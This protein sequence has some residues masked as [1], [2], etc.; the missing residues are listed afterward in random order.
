[1]VDTYDLSG[2][3]V[4]FQ[5]RAYNRP[6]L[7]PIVKAIEYAKKRD[8]PAVLGYCASSQVAHKLVQNDLLDGFAE[9]LQVTRIGKG[10]E[11]VE[12]GVCHFDV[13]KLAGRWRIVAFNCNVDNSALSITH[14]AR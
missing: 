8:Y 7:V 14:R 2:D 5:A 4:R 6:D 9:D 13:Q 10:K 11:H 1:M 12:I 3:N